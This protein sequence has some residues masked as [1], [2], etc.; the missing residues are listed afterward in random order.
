MAQAGIM[1]LTEVPPAGDGEGT[2]DMKARSANIHSDPKMGELK[3]YMKSHQHEMRLRESA[4]LETRGAASPTAGRGRVNLRAEGCDVMD[5]KLKVLAK[6]EAVVPF[7]VKTGELPEAFRERPS[8]KQELQASMEERKAMLRRMDNYSTRLTWRESMDHSLRRL[9]VDLDL[10]RDERLKEYDVKQKSEK[11]EG[12]SPS[13]EEEI[14]KTR[15]AKARCEHLDKIYN[16]YEIHGMKEAR[17]ERK[18]PPY[19]RYNPQHPV[20]PGSMRVAPPLRELLNKSGGGLSHS[21]SSPALLAAGSA[22]TGSHS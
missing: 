5:E 4:E 17:K 10:S 6:N 20:M 3:H 19:L 18:A 16:W 7:L 22:T 9:M 11:T 12:P 8:S 1:S 2:T 14:Q 15:F 13:I 21:S